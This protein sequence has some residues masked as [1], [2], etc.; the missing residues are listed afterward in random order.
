MRRSDMILLSAA[1]AAALMFYIIIMYSERPGDAVRVTVDGSIYAQYPLDKDTDVIIPGKKGLNNRLVIS[2]GEADI[3]E[4]ACP[5]KLCV[6]QKA[7]KYDG[8]TIVC[9]PNRVVVEV[10]SESS[11]GVDAVAQ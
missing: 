1:I 6:R 10:I 11:N 9:L 4:A 7:I 8:E 3:V 2:G 5:D